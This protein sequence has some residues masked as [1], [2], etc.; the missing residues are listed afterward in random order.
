RGEDERRRHCFHVSPPRSFVVL[1]SQDLRAGLRPCRSERC[2]R[3][4]TLREKK[5]GSCADSPRPL[6][7]AL[8]AS[9]ESRPRRGGSVQFIAGVPRAASGRAGRTRCG[10]RFSKVW[11]RRRFTSA[12]FARRHVPRLASPCGPGFSFFMAGI[13]ARSASPPRD[14]LV[15]L[16]R[17]E[18]PD[19]LRPSPLAMISAA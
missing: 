2:R 12:L 9:P 16:L 19:G 10:R 7:S 17:R 13:L 15:K 11:R 14:G 1:V 3:R 4:L 18:A 6:G 8:S 5:P